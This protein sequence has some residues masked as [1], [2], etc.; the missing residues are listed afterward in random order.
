MNDFANIMSAAWNLMCTEFTLYGFT[1]S[2]GKMYLFSL[3]SGLVILALFKY[4]WG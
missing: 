4:L 1:I 3:I 2:Y